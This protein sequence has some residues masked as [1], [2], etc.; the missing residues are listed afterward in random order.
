MVGAKGINFGQRGAL[1]V[2]LEQDLQVR[3]VAPTC[4]L[5]E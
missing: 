3:G 2:Q 5:F 4:Y 1:G